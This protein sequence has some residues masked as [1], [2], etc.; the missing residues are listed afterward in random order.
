ML[1]NVLAGVDGVVVPPPDEPELFEE[2][3]FDELEDE[4]E[5]DVLFELLVVFLS[6]AIVIVIVSPL[7]IC[8][9]SAML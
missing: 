3:L 8:V 4:L 6:V 2:L 1:L 5:L 9:P 7:E